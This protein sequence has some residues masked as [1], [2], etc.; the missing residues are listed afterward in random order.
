[1]RKHY[2]TFA[3]VGIVHSI[4]IAER[5]C[6]LTV[7]SD[8]KPRRE[9]EAAR[10]AS[11]HLNVVVAYNDRLK[12]IFRTLTEGDLVSVRGRTRQPSSGDRAAYLSLSELVAYEAKIIIDPA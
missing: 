8:Y 3:I 4:R 6:E 11:R 10:E 1:M 9:G 2:S 5:R 7:R 12:A